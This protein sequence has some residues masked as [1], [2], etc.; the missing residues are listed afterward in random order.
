VDL[1]CGDATK[2]REKLGWEPEVS[3]QELVKMMVEV[4]LE[5]VQKAENA[6]SLA[7]PV[8]TFALPQAKLHV[9]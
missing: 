7:A 3:F 4:D 2:A 5:M 8:Q 6:Y 9:I 1:L